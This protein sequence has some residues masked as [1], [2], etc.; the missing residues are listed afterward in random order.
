MRFCPTQAIRVRRGLAK[1]FSPLCLSCGEC[2]KV[3]PENAILPLTDSFTLSENFDIRVAV[4]SPVLYSQF[5]DDVDPARILAALRHIG[6]D[7][8]CDIGSVC[9]LFSQG[10]HLHLQANRDRWPMISS[11][12]PTILR[13]IQVKY[14]GLVDRII[15]FDTPREIVARD[16]KLEIS[17]REGVDIEKI[18]AIYLT[19]CP[20]KMISIRHP[21][22]KEK[23]WLDGA[24]SIADIYTP[25]RQAL[26][27]TSDQ[28]I[29]DTLVGDTSFGF[30]WARAGLMGQSID[31]KNSIS[32]S[33]LP[34]VMKLFDHL[35]RSRLENVMFIEACA[36][37]E[38]CI[39]GSLTVEN[40]Y[41]ARRN[42]DLLQELNQHREAPSRERIEILYKQGYFFV[43]KGLDPTPQEPLHPN[44][45]KAIIKRN[46]V[47]RV[48]KELPGIDCGVC[49]SPT[50]QV[51][52]EDYARGEVELIECIHLT[53]QTVA[54]LE[55]DTVAM[56]SPTVK[57]PA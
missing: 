42:L 34:H 41:V 8:V 2:I 7:F 14:P 26:R 44:I 20:A 25:L 23:S 13:L 29:S 5:G 28:D 35:E 55:R 17:R 31:W 12:C 11:L 40:V 6:F 52:A 39:G 54:E 38:G 19:P 33:G 30:S 16:A 27:K 9:E 15:P 56:S 53:T 3:C 37:P 22:Q 45:G 46:L 57:K 4:P 36:C 32:V 51:F 47:E 21:P 43:E 18:G 1:I 50:C 24:I 49:G 10:Y 48:V